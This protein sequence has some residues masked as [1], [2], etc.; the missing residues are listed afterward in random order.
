MSVRRGLPEPTK[1]ANDHDLTLQDL[2]HER[3]RRLAYHLQCCLVDRRRRIQAAC[4][5][6]R[7]RVLSFATFLTMSGIGENVLLI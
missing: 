2:Q 6:W 7:I 3:T 1:G 5:G 4:R